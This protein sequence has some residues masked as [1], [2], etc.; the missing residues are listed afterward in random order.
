MQV[1]LEITYRGVEKTDA[2]DALVQEKVAKLEE[3]C[4]YITSC[5]IAIEKPHDRPRS[6][7]PYR[8]RLDITVPPGHEL[9]ATNNPGA[10]TQYEEIDVAIRDAFDAARRQ[11][12]KLN[13]RQHESDKGKT[14]AAPETIALVTQIFRDEGYGFL[15]TLEGEEIYFHRNSVLHDDFDRLEI[16]TGVRFFVEQGEQGPQASTVQIVNKPGSRVG[17]SGEE[18]IEPPLGWQ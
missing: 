10:D 8:V 1:P 2:L 15:K 9:V 3:V 11:L 12:R 6:G 14:H 4:D 7:S 13:K 16:G 18:E 5:H 17:K